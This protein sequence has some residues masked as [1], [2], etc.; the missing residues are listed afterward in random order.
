MVHL[1]LQG[2]VEGICLDRV[3]NDDKEEIKFFLSTRSFLCLLLACNIRSDSFLIVGL[4][5]VSEVLS[6]C[7]VVEFDDISILNFYLE[8]SLVRDFVELVL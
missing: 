3:G 6:L 8:T 1:I 5:S 2:I 4:N 7:S